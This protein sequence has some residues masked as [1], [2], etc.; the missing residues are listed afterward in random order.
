MY[1]LSVLSDVED[2]VSIKE[3]IYLYGAGTIGRKIIRFLKLNEKLNLV[4]NIFVSETPEYGKKI[5]GVPVIKYK[6][7]LVNQ[8]SF[9]LVSSTLFRDDIVSV[10]KENT[11][12][13]IVLDR[14][15][16]QKLD[17][18]FT[19]YYQ[20]YKTEV[21]NDIIEQA[22]QNRKASKWDIAFISPPYWDVYSPFSAVPC[23]K[24][25]LEQEGYR[26]YQIDLGI[27]SIRCVMEKYGKEIAEEILSEE[28][29]RNIICLYHKN[30]YSS[31]P[32]FYDA[33]HF[34]Q[35]E[36]D[37]DLMKAEYETYN[38][39]QKCVINEFYQRAYWRESF[40]ID[41]DRCQSL[42]QE[43][44]EK[45]P[46]CLY[47]IFKEDSVKHLLEHLPDVVGISI[48]S[49]C[50]FL[51]GCMI[52]DILHKVKPDIKL[53]FGGSCADLFINSS[54][55]N[56]TEIYDFFDYVMIGEGETGIKK[57]M[58]C[59]K[60]KTSLDQIPNLIVEENGKLSA[61]ESKIEDVLSL[62]APDFADLDLSLYLSPYLIL[63]YQTSR[64]CHYGHCAFCNHDEKYRHNYRSKQM[65]KV[66]EDLIEL[67]QK[68]NCHYIQFVDEAIEPDCF[69]LMVEEMERNSDFQDI[70]WFY[71]SRVSMKYNKELLDKAYENGCRMVMFGIETFNNRLLKFI[72]KGISAETS[73]YCLK[74]FHDSKIKV[75]AWFMDNLPSETIEEA[76][77]DL[78][79]LK[80]NI[81]YIDSFA[82]S[83]FTLVKN[84]DMYQDLEKYNIL[85]I[86][87]ND[88]TRFQSHFEGKIIDREEMLR[89]H[90]E[91]Y[92]K[93]QFESVL[94]ANRYTIFFD[95]TGV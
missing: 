71:Y 86:D 12:N 15:F 44:E 82:I 50:Q 18:Y 31:F 42:R 17:Q 95:G 62:P 10:L 1:I 25:K 19:N 8:N 87:D 52:A 39:I 56:K 23:L 43:L 78:K 81:E 11:K 21:C 64:G 48:T 24:A 74:L 2:F 55:P 88:T 51:Q 14:D 3:E 20:N 37:V 70:K 53:I 67:K 92:L 58:D 76:K 79:E 89:F 63:P 36:I 32:E 30:S 61:K 45:K 7:E 13:L 16:E 91:E 9:V 59:M 72:R 60:H 27:L 93:F 40:S 22:K 69:K 66:V 85:D 84:T 54:Y 49:T 28:F 47:E 65:K 94:T 46:I 34:L 80:R 68:Y 35:G 38:F 77:E 90:R 83:V 4:R 41:F 6:P 57:L 75:Y 26:T 33:M 29:Y 73:K 5:S